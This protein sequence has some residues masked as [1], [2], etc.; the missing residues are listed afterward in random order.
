MRLAPPRPVRLRFWRPIRYLPPPQWSKPLKLVREVCA[1]SGLWSPTDILCFNCASQKGC[2]FQSDSAASCVFTGAS[3]E[4]IENNFFFVC[5]QTWPRISWVFQL[6]WLFPDNHERKL[7]IVP[8]EVYFQILCWKQNHI[9]YLINCL[10]L[11]FNGASDGY[12]EIIYE[13]ICF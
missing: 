9:W 12:L 6:F 10:P 2:L 11:I 8:F 5:G 13:Q 1:A 3:S 4:I 7:Q